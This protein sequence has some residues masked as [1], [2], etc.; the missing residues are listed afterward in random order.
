MVTGQKWGGEKWG[1]R[2]GGARSS[3]PQSVYS[4]APDF[5]RGP[6]QGCLGLKGPAW[7]GQGL[8]E[9]GG[10]AW[11]GTGG[12][13]SATP[14]LWLGLAEGLEEEVP[15]GR[16]CTGRTPPPGPLSSQRHPWAH[17]GPAAHGPL[18]PSPRPP[19]RLP[20]PPSCLPQPPTQPKSHL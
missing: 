3:S 1:A 8:W 16:G 17:V 12:G 6:S 4:G 13:P 14:P 7:L 19:R 18:P 20:G 9:A 11:E 10:R 15:Q 2:S 5:S